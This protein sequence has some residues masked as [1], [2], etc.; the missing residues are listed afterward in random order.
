MNI[1]LT[2][3]VGTIFYTLASS[4]AGVNLDLLRMRV[5]DVIF[6]AGVITVAAE[7]S[8]VICIYIYIYYTFRV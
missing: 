4:L 8:F 6:V 5:N 2:S 7:I 3:I 1:A